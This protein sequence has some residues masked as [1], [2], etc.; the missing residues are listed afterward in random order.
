MLDLA[1]FIMLANRVF[2]LCGHVHYFVD[3]PI[4]SG[5]Q[6]T[7]IG[8]VVFTVFDGLT[9]L[10]DAIVVSSNVLFWSLAAGH[11]GAAL[12]QVTVAASG[13]GMT[14]SSNTTW[15]SP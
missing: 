2:Q 5:F 8:H 14:T 6:K 15:I 3:A 4:K 1:L 7:R 9:F 10:G 13:R 11:M 12:L